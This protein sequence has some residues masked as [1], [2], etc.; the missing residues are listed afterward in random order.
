MKD[1]QQL[2][3]EKRYLDA[4]YLA[5]YRNL[6]YETRELFAKE[7]Y[8]SEE[9]KDAFE[10]LLLA[11][12]KEDFDIYNRFLDF[13]QPIA[14]NLYLDRQKYLKPINDDITRM[15]FPVK[16]E[17]NPEVI[18]IKLRTRSAKSEAIGN[19]ASFWVQGNFPHGETLHVVG[20]G[21]LRDNI[22]KKRVQFIDEY[23]E[24]HVQ[25]F[26]NAKVFDVSKK[27]AK[28][29]F[30]NSEYADITTVTSGGSIEGF[31]QVTNLLILDDLVASNEIN[32]VKRLE[33]IFSS[34]IMNAIMRRYISGGI[35]LVGTP[36]PTLTGIKEPLDRF[37]DDRR[38]GGYNCVEHIVPS[39]NENL[40]SNYAYRDW[41]TKDGK[42]VWRFTTE[43]FLK[44]R[45][46]AYAEG[47][48]LRIANFETI[49]QMKPMDAGDKRFAKIKRYSEL[50]D[51]KYREINV[52]DPADKGADGA[53]MMNCRVY[54]S[55]PNTNYVLEIFHDRRPMDVEANGG[56]LND[57]ARF[58]I[59]NE[60]Q[61]FEYEENLGGT[62]LGNKLVDLC[63]EQGHRVSFNT[64][65]QVKNKKERIL[66]MALKTLEATRLRD[67]IT[68][69]KQYDIAAQE[70]MGWGHLS[71]HDDA[72]DCL[73]RVSE[74]IEGKEDY[75]FSTK[76][77]KFMVLNKPLI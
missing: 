39:L 61:Y 14:R 54:D 22:H 55:E 18:R 60:I 23:W 12:A 48:P 35:L 21:N 4:S 46:A 64:Y 68:H 62:L 56:Y 50:P 74:I 52:L 25:V 57:L 47:E 40:E 32:S 1:I 59:H 2:M 53:V 33:D 8:M 41:N 26:P 73:T 67:D 34:D 65:R 72:I 20:G 19:R 15:F 63:A 5:I 30:R 37:L 58:I 7:D 70:I 43:D 31:V 76:A 11:D 45:Q 13:R 69:T 10:N 27:D 71:K 44:E 36:I 77:A 42:P 28:V 6:T 51:D 24:R 9:K 17:E 49:Y 3:K 29:W 66:D 75:G 16:G 38:A